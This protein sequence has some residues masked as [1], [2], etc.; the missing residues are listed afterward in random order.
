[1]VSCPCPVTPWVSGGIALVFVDFG[2]LPDLA[3]V[4]SRAA[5]VFSLLSSLSLRD[6]RPTVA[7]PSE[8]DLVGG[9]LR[10]L[11]V[12]VLSESAMVGG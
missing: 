3:G 4:L 9:S 10:D 5:F 11:R 1:M 7:V 8:S 12:A 6:L 2:S